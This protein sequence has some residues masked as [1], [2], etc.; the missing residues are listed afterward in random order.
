MADEVRDIRY[1]GRRFIP[2]YSRRKDAPEK[3]GR[4][5]SADQ[6]NPKHLTVVSYNCL[7]QERASAAEF[8]Y[9]RAAVLNW[10]NRRTKLLK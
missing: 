7:S 2:V 9:A 10:R 5:D 1:G 6:A 3:L 4:F 8:P